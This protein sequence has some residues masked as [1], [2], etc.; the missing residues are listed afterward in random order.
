MKKRSGIQSACKPHT[1]R[2]FAAEE[3]AAVCRP[4]VGGARYVPRRCRGQRHIACM[5][6]ERPMSI[7]ADR[8]AAVLNAAD[9]AD[10]DN[11]GFF[12]A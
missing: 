6:A 8:D 4:H 1:I 2:V 10:T 3:G 12:R 9:T 11:D 7:A 5:Q